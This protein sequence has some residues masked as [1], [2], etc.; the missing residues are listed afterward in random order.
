MN[1][2]LAQLLDKVQ[3]TAIEVSDTAAD[4]GGIAA[5]AAYGVG[6]KAGELL[7]VAKLKI[8]IAETQ[9]QVNAALQ[10]LGELL[11]A[12][13]T[14]N[15]TDSEILLQKLQEVD[16]LKAQIA[17]LEAQIC[18][19]EAARTCPVCAAPVQEGDAYC[20]ECGSKL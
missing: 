17:G 1:E 2:K 19:E 10:E 12:T 8:R 13:H 7:C 11:Y 20:R 6:K 14:G 3:N 15:P 5:D 16:A 9:A 4:V 18:R